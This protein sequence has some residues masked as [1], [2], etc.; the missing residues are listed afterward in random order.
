MKKQGIKSLAFIAAAGVMTTSCD[1][2][3]D[4]DYAVTPDPLEMHGDSVRVKVD[5][6]LP[7]KGI[8][9]KAYAEIT[10]SLGTHALKPVTI[11][12]EKATANGTVIPYKPG[13]KVVYEDI[14]AYSPDMEV[15]QLTVTGKV[16]KGDK[17]KGVVPETKIADA[18]IVTPLWVNK[19]FRVIYEKDKFQRTTMEKM[20]AEIHYLKGRSEVRS[21]E[22]KD[23]DIM[24]MK[25]FLAETQK[26]PKLAI[27]SINITAFASIE[28]EE[29]KN[30]TLSTERANTAKQATMKIAA[31][32]DV[33][34]EAAQKEETYST[35]GKGE[36]FEGFKKALAASDMEK[37]EKDLIMNILEMQK[38]PTARE[39]AMRDLGKT[40]TYL[41]KN[42]FPAQRRA[43]IVINYEK[44]GYSDEELKALSKSNIDT[45]NIEEILFTATLTDD[46]NEKLRLYKEAAR[47]F[48]NDH[49][50]VNN[51]GTVL[52]MQNKLSEAKTQFEKAVSI[53]ENPISKN[54]L[55]AIAG[56]NGDRNKA[57][58]LLKEASGAGSEVSYNFGIL[59][60]QD[61]DYEEA[62]SKF[63]G[64]ASF[65]KALAQLLN[66]NIDAAVK[67]VNASKDAETAQGYYLKAIAGA[68]QDKLDDIVSNL[69]SA[70]AKDASLKA[71][72]AKDREFIKYHDNASF[73][74][75]VK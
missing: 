73:T 6:T 20:T 28:G 66:E 24:E 13:G 48:P 1:L 47:L 33:A 37:S 39:Q 25:N 53:K 36:D 54:N 38:T 68:R 7:E 14:I 42:I 30:N 2:L 55:G 16:Y 65:N 56:V 45:L 75:I 41:D 50:P 21:T 44:T 17:E 60:I 22:L 18:T 63:G 71:K 5:I 35:V 43:E 51:M 15:S 11:V 64:E 3:K 27:K 10:P 74:A 67:T 8:K 49:R 9:K 4:L 52:Y 40:F 19:D 46:L 70:F 12:G 32:K 29:D 72:A 26:N 23:K 58:S 69:K 31:Q 34:N 57:K 59:A 61:G 62:V